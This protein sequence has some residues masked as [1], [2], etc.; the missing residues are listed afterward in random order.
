MEP[1]TNRRKYEAGVKLKVIKMAKEWNNCAAARAFDITEKMVREWRKNEDGIKRMPMEK[2]SMRRGIACWP[3]LENN[4]AE[5][6]QEERQ[7]C[8]IVTKNMI[9]VYALKWARANAE[10][11]KEFKATMSWCNRFM[12]RKNLVMQQKTKIDLFCYIMVLVYNFKNT[13]L[14]TYNIRRSPGLGGFF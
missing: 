5:W 6:V 10:R 1:Q 11:S 8:N 7:D 14:C 4:V 9:R 12:N 2:F 3:D 13:L